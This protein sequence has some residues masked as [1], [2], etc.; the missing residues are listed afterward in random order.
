MDE[1]KEEDAPLRSRDIGQHS[2]S[3]FRLL[4]SR[5]TRA[6]RTKTRS[7]LPRHG[8]DDDSGSVVN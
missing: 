1:G 6:S 3:E 8:G 2:A 4:S 7:R 5:S